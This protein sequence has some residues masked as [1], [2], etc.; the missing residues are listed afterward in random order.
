MFSR[1][2]ASPSEEET[3]RGTNTSHEMPE[4]LVPGT[5]LN[6]RYRIKKV[7]YASLTSAMYLAE[8]VK[9]TAR[10][11]AVKECF[12]PVALPE[13][14]PM[15]RDRL[16]AEVEK[17]KA[18]S[19]PHLA[20]IIDSFSEGSREY[21]IMEFVDGATLQGISKMSVSFLPERQILTWALAV[22]DTLDFLHHLSP[23]TYFRE[24]APACIMLDKEE[25]VK[26]INF[27]FDRILN[28]PSPDVPPTEFLAPE[29]AATYSG[30]LQSTPEGGEKFSV[31]TDIYSLGMTLY[32]LFTK[33]VPS[34]VP[35]PSLMKINPD[36]DFATEE[37]VLKCV[38]QDSSAR[39]QSMG[40]LKHAIEQILTPPKQ[41]A[42]MVRRPGLL[43]SIG[44]AMA[45]GA[46]RVVRKVKWGTA[47]LFH[48]V[49]VAILALIFGAFFLL[50]RHVTPVSP[51]FTRTSPLAYVLCNQGTIWVV[52]L[53]SLKML[54]QIPLEEGTLN[55]A[56]S[57]QGKL[58]FAPNYRTGTMQV[59][60][61][62][63]NRLFMT[64]RVPAGSQG[65]AVD[66]SGRFAFVATSS[67]HQLSTVAVDSG[68]VVALTPTGRR[69]GG[70]VVSANG[71]EV[72]VANV[73]SNSI[74]VIDAAKHSVL[75]TLSTGRG[76]R[77]LALSLEGDRLFVANEG[78]KD[79]YIFDLASRTLK[80][81][82]P[83]EGDGPYHLGVSPRG[84]L[85]LSCENGNVLLVYDGATLQRLASLPVEAPGSVSFYPQG[86]LALLA[87]GS[88]NLSLIDAETFRIKQ[89]I[90]VGRNPIAL[91]VVP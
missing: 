85:Y 62:L 32:Y 48:P 14:R 25:R 27:G 66:P 59:I 34:T 77:E 45:L 55:L 61:T 19:H 83:M 46:G 70:V 24:L 90:K 20:K 10:V 1:V 52:D 44:D 71:D 18:A 60:E 53:P 79:L 3:Q 72:Y 42:E 35:P 76:P 68:S 9:V 57:P 39:P 28:P 47:Y 13:D 2:W 16:R 26:L 29:I 7:L 65:I 6:E 87:N 23:P 4:L 56:I 43:S 11:W 51:D 74:S 58:L 91:V 38:S 84:D 88:S 50:Y 86:K 63:H 41:E 22:C 40:E 30:E 15:L 8:D 64:I 36:L 17:L 37:L 21:V 31:G 33:M 89:T 81:I 54:H 80:S 73:E 67:D 78:S 5:L 75:A 69:P 49:R 12:P 82:I